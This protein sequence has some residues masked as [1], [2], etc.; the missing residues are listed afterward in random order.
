[1]GG[2]VVAYLGLGANLGDRE[3]NLRRAVERLS[4]TPGVRVLDV[5]RLRESAPAGGPP[6]GPYLNS[7]ARIE[8]TLDAHA[9]LAVC[10][11][12]ER[13]L[14]RAPDRVRNAPRPVDL[15]VLL[16]GDQRIDTGDLVVPHPRMF[17]REF[18]LEPLRDLG[19]DV[20]ALPRP[21]LRPV[22]ESDPHTFA[23]RCDTWRRGG[24]VLGL[25]PTMGALH[26][27]HAALLRRARAECDRVAASIFVNPLQFATGEDLDRYPRPLERDL[28]VCA[29]E[30]VDVVFTP[31]GDAMYGDGFCSTIDVGREAEGM[32]GAVRPGH[33]RGVVTV[34][35]RLW[36]LARPDRAYFGR[37]DAQQVAVI[38]RLRRDLG[39]P[40]ELVECEIVRESDGLAMSSRNAY[41]SSD[42]RAAAPVLRRALDAAV[43]AHA[44]GERRASR[45]RDVAVAVLSAEARCT[46]DY[47]ELRRDDDLGALPDGVEVTLARM[48]I[49][50]RLGATRL[51]DNETIGRRGDT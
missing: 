16:F 37:K 42:D 5:A 50:A 8:T 4:A 44:A 49:A 31:S 23:A 10:K 17:D 13:E 15:D 6:Q 43:R 19:V 24:A 36:S 20:D 30:G 33:F 32:E 3:G 11:A 47:V 38:G 25:V 48:L 21:H 12:I 22:V 35:A 9:L 41:L 7:A 28:D 39:L 2:P 27:G 45:L 26:E 40:G 29:R 34:V 46:P 14:G 18:V 1:M 51:I